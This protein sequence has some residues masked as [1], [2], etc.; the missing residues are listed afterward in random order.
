MAVVIEV[1]EDNDT[2][3]ED[4]CVIGWAVEICDWDCGRTWGVDLTEFEE[5]TKGGIAAE[6]Q[7]VLRVGETFT[8]E[9]DV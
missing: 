4:V 3:V 1:D 9:E 8:D 2:G 7:I 5:G 6:L